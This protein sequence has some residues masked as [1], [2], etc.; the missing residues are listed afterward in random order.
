MLL[1]AGCVFGLA[2]VVA[3]GLLFLNSKLKISLYKYG[4]SVLVKY[5]S[6]KGDKAETIR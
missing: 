2:V 3:L 1:L 4:W 5:V 6:Q